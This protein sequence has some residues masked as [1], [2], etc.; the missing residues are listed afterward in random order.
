VHRRQRFAW[1]LVSFI[2]VCS[3]VAPS[4]SAARAAEI[5]VAMPDGAR[6]VREPFL[7]YWQALGGA[8]RLGNPTTDALREDTPNGPRTVQYFAYARL[9]AQP[10]GGVRVLGAQRA[11]A[12]TTIDGFWRATFA[13]HGWHYTSPVATIQFAQPDQPLCGTIVL[14]A[15]VG[16]FFCSTSSTIYVDR[17]FLRHAHAVLGEMVITTT[18]AH[19][20]GHH[21]QAL[22]GIGGE[23]YTRRQREAQA[24]CFAGA[25]IGALAQ[26]G[27]Y[28]AEEIAAAK[29]F[30]RSIGDRR[31]DALRN[32][33]GHGTPDQRVQMFER[34]LNSGAD[35]CELPARAGTQ[36]A[37]SGERLA[38]TQ[39]AIRPRSD[40]RWSIK[41]R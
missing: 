21:L 7:G 27:A 5:C 2:I 9:E 38:S 19:E 31:P 41:P 26:Q 3:V 32:P 34:G 39:P 15:K 36:A 13:Q 14:P 28:S 24:D 30:L 12:A 20:W 18:I 40:S 16:P 1:L 22:R 33:H 11:A 37:A 10:D 35:A 4:R 23:E 8:A 29:A 25:Y 6:C 17:A